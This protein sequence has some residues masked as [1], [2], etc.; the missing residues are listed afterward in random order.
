MTK[1]NV[2]VP[3]RNCLAFVDRTLGSLAF[4]TRMPD[5]VVVIDDASDQAGYA[6][7]CREWCDSYDGWS[8]LHLTERH[9]CPMATRAGIAELKAQGAQPDEVVFT[10][11]G[12]DFLPSW[13]LARIDEVYNDPDVW[14]TYGQY[15]PY[16][17]NT[18]QTLASA[19][20]EYVIH[21]RTFRYYHVT[22]F[23]HPRTFRIHLFDHLTDADFQTA[24]GDWFTA[25]GDYI[26]MYPMLEMAG[27]EHYRFLDEVLYFYNAINPNSESQ[28]IP[29][30][31][32]ETH[33][34][35]TRPIRDRVY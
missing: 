4:Q 33:Q 14:L 11:D 32:Q 15:E 1:I 18:G 25:G 13:S 12:D 8:V 34:I 3:S 16:P 5:R 2:V 20:P 17:E 19:Y 9:W 21:D 31:G 26:V 24:E 27:G 22:G 30:K 23:N 6:Q 28:T 10:L 29:D 35:I 7:R